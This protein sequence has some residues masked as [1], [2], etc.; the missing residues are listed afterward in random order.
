MS[1]QHADA[2]L[3][4]AAEPIRGLPGPLPKGES[5]LWQ[6]KPCW[7]NLAVRSFHIRKVAIY[8]AVLL[9][10][11]VISAVYDHELST[12]IEPLFELVGLGC[13]VMGIIALFCWAVEKTTVY[14]V[15]TRRVVIRAGIAL[16]KTINIPYPRI[17]RVDL[18]MRGASHGDILLTPMPDD[19]LA[20]LVLW[21]HVQAWH[22]RQGRPML[23]SIEA[24]AE[25]ARMI[26]ASVATVLAQTE[27]VTG[28]KV[29]A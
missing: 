14:T 9:V 7:R 26:G 8:F 27:P 15:T 16:P 4:D 3:Y 25:V 2:H 20:Y 28:E 13:I 10:W 11:D 23:R 18:R 29:A 24:P 22:F 12:V 5:I 1:E 19:R 17:D 6:G 21:P